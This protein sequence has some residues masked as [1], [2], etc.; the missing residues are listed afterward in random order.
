[1]TVHLQQ[2]WHLFDLL[3]ERISYNVIMISI[4]SVDSVLIVARIALD[5]AKYRSVEIPFFAVDFSNFYEEAAQ[6]R[7]REPIPMV[8]II[9]IVGE[10][11]PSIS[12]AARRTAPFRQRPVSARSRL[13]DTRHGRGDR[14]RCASARR[15]A[16]C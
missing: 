6:H 2:R 5:I 3:Q 1:M 8:D 13:E 9:D 15:L 16:R 4:I 10:P 12:D 7:M 14:F 11:P